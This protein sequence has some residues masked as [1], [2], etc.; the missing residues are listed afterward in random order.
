MDNGH[1]QTLNQTPSDLSLQSCE[2]VCIVFG[3]LSCSDLFF[4]TRCA[5]THKTQCLHQSVV[6]SGTVVLADEKLM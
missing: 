3:R 4:V 6:F 1:L 2:L 5:I